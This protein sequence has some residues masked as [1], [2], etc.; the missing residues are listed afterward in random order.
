M[1]GNE[2]STLLKGKE[3]FKFNICQFLHVQL[4]KMNPI[5]LVN[6]HNGYGVTLTGQ[7]LPLNVSSL[8]DRD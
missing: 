3:Y 8:L 4:R 5:P 6:K 2:R 1:L 7:N